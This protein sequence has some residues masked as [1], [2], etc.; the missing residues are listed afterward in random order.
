MIVAGCSP[1]WGN[2]LARAYP[3][4]FKN[5]KIWPAARIVTLSD[6][7]FCSSAMLDELGWARLEKFRLKQLDVQNSYV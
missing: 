7:E 6:Y 1:V 3:T 2:I 5:Y 4:N